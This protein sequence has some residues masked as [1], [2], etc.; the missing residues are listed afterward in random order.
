MDREK[1]D[2]GVR[3]RTSGKFKLKDRMG[4]NAQVVHIKQFG[5][6]PDTIIMERVGGSWFTISAVLTPAELKKQEKIDKKNIKQ[7]KD[8]NK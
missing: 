5:F 7:L 4:M 1:V 8:D 2:E 3:V 6:I